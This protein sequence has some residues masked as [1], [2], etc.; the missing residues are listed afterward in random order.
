[1]GAKILIV[2]VFLVIVYNLGAAFWYML[3]DRS[4]S[5]RTVNA[6]TRRI[7]ISVGLIVLVMAAIGAGIIEP[8]GVFPGR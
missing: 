1:M 4:K 2:A 8:H 3:A 5:D 6:L 7:G